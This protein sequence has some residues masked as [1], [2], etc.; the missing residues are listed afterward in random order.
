MESVAAEWSA[1]EI[2]V[3]ARAVVNAPSV[4]N[5]QPWSLE[6][7]DGEAL[8]SERT[9]L[10]LPYHDPAG[11]D[12]AVSCGAAAANLELGM[13]VLGRETLLT[14]LPDPLRPELVARVTASDVRLPS[15]LDL[16]RYSAI[17]RRHSYRHAFTGQCVSDYD[18]TDLVTASHA[19]GVTARP[20]RGAAEL[21]AL[22]DVLEYAGAALRQDDGYQ[23]ELTLW[24][25]RG[26]AR[27]GDGLTLAAAASTLP[28]A[29][30]VRRGTALP[31]RET[32]AARLGRETVLV[33]LT[34]DD[35]RLD[36]VRTG[37]AMEQTW[38]AAVDMGL[39][40]AV[41]T[42]P[43]HVAEARSAL[44]DDLGLP[45]YP[46]LFMRV[47]HPAVA[48]PCSPRRAIGDLLERDPL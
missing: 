5:M 43:L 21:T 27:P 31:D 1:G 46:Q 15:A 41:Q 13:R 42:Q 9:D 36:H 35:T 30:L 37:V 8:L 16:H 25:A 24:T 10:V 3:L 4:H 12:L 7:P 26:G 28:W 40:A 22:A 11:R 17:A 19:A 44:I 33:F 39:A 29:G 45:G 20:L 34:A 6:L 18:L 47:G 23:R 2:D 32:L 48:V 38:L 14:L